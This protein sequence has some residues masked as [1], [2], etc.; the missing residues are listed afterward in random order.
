MKTPGKLS[1]F[2][3]GKSTRLFCFV[4]LL[5]SILRIPAAAQHTFSIVAVDSATGEVGSAGATC[6]NNSNCNNCGGAV[7]ISG[8]VPG[9]GA[10]NAQASVCIPNSNLNSAITFMQNGNSPLQILA[11]LMIFEPCG[12]GDTSNRQYGIVDLD[13]NGS[14]RVAAFSGSNTMS[15]SNHITGANYSIQGNILLGPEILDSMQAGFLNTPGPLCDKLMA[16]LQGANVIGADTRCMDDSTSSLSSYIR[17]AKPGDSATFWLDIIIPE[18]PAFVEPIDSLQKAFDAWKLQNGIAVGTIASGP[19]VY[20]NPANDLI[21][22]ELYEMNS[23]PVFIRLINPSGQ[24]LAGTVIQ[25]GKKKSTIGLDQ[26]HLPSGIYF[27][28]GNNASH[29]INFSNTIRID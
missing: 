15:Y 3:I 22:I 6:L 23:S 14:P 20:P 19:K 13:S 4:L 21:T 1:F 29:T 28:T 17:V 27:V 26:L 8:L 25:P 18:V 9:V 2:A 10:V 12:P 16:A 5:F 24:K 11:N 7:I